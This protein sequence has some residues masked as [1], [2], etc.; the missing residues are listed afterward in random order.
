MS[1]TTPQIKKNKV[2]SRIDKTNNIVDDEIAKQLTEL[3]VTSS[4]LDSMIEILQDRVVQS[5]DVG[6]A[7]ALARFY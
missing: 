4:D 7:I 2:E 1:D 3:E 6:L 5:T